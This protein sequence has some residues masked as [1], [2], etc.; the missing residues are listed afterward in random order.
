VNQEPDTRPGFYYVDMIG[1]N[2]DVALL[3]GPYPTHAEALAM[4]DTARRIAAQTNR[5][6][7]VFASFGTL[8]SEKDL[9]LGILHRY[10]LLPHIVGES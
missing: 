7:T 1:H 10:N 2:R 9:G 4:L 6:Q 5:N 8:R 3:A